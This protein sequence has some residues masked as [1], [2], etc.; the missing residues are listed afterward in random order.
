LPDTHRLKEDFMNLTHLIALCLLT[1]SVTTAYAQEDQPPESPSPPPAL[2]DV[3]KVVQAIGADKVTLHIYC[4]LGQLSD[5]ITA[6]DERKDAATADA[7]S[8]QAYDL[9]EELGPD[10][11]RVTDG[12]D[13]VDPQTVDGKTL[14]AA[15]DPLDQQCK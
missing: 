14:Y 1:P 5:Q 10:Y 15:W 9:A 2:A 12:M 13:G 11:M 8:K 3:Q 7:L 6:A 4:Q